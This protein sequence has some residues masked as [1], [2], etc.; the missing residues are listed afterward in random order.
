MIK[1]FNEDNM[2]FD[3]YEKTGYRKADVIFADCIYESHEFSWTEKYWNYLN[4]NGL[5]FIIT[6]FHSVSE[7]DVHM[8]KEIGAKRIN[9]VVWKNEW[10][11][12]PSNKFHEC[13]DEILI[14][15]K[16]PKWRFNKEKVQ[17]PKATAK[18]K[19][20]NPSGRETKTQTAW[21]D[22]FTLTTVAKERIV[23]DDGHLVR[24]QKPKSLVRQLMVPFL[25]NGHLV[26]DPFMGSGTAGEV[27]YEE[28]WHYIGIEYD[29]AIFKLANKRLENFIKEDAT[30]YYIPF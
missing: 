17:V 4:D 21:F 24:W 2:K 13:Y 15:S 20:L 12:P 23:M 9:K 14:Y 26:L 1:L 3:L 28:G 5:F 11:K 29:K 8:K 22:N 30:E 16:S 19:G 27:S 25:L 7:I 18:S 6:D 10:G